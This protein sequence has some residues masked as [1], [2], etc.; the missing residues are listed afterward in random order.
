MRGVRTKATFDENNVAEITWKFYDAADCE[1][2]GSPT[3]TVR[4][5][6]TYA[7]G[8]SFTDE[9]AKERQPESDDATL[10]KLDYTWQSSWW[11]AHTNTG[12]ATLHKENFCTK[13]NIAQTGTV[14]SIN[15]GRDLVGDSCLDTDNNMAM[16]FA[17]TN[18]Y[19][20]VALAGGSLIWGGPMATCDEAKRPGHFDMD[21]G[22]WKPPSSWDISGRW[23]QGKCGADRTHQEITITQHTYRQRTWYYSDESCTQKFAT[24]W[25]EATYSLEGAGWD[26]STTNINIYPYKQVWSDLDDQA[27]DF[28]N[29]GAGGDCPGYIN[30]NE[31]KVL[32][33]EADDYDA[34]DVDDIQYDGRKC[35]PIWPMTGCSGDFHTI[36]LKD[37]MLSITRR[38][39]NGN[40]TVFSDVQLEAPIP[41]CSPSNRHQFS[42]SNMVQF[43]KLDF[44]HRDLVG[45]WSS[46]ECE[47][48][49]NGMGSMLK[50]VS[51]GKMKTL[52]KEIE[53]FSDDDCRMPLFSVQYS[54]M[55]WVDVPEGWRMPK[56]AAGGAAGDAGPPAW[57]GEEWE[58]PE[59]TERLDWEPVV[60]HNGKR[61]Q[62]GGAR[63]RD[64]PN[65]GNGFPDKWL[66]LRISVSSQTITN[67]N[68]Q[69]HEWLEDCGEMFAP[70]IATDISPAKKNKCM[71]KACSGVDDAV[72]IDGWGRLAMGGKTAWFDCGAQNNAVNYKAPLFR[73]RRGSRGD[74]GQD[75]LRQAQPLDS[76]T[77]ARAQLTKLGVVDSAL[78]QCDSRGLF[79]QKQCSGVECWCVDAS[80][81]MAQ[82]WS[83]VY[84][85]DEVV[86]C[87]P[88]ARF[89]S[90]DLAGR[91]APGAD[92]EQIGS[93]GY[94][95]RT[96]A[97]FHSRSL[98]ITRQF[99]A[100][101]GCTGTPALMA[102]SSGNYWLK[103]DPSG[104]ADWAD[105]KFHVRSRWWKADAT[106]WNTFNT[107]EQRTDI[108]YMGANVPQSINCG[109]AEWNSDSPHHDVLLTGCRL[110][111]V[112]NAVANCTMENHAVS[113]DRDTGKLSWWST[114][115]ADGA[116][117]CQ[118][119]RQGSNIQPV[120]F[121]RTV[122]ATDVQG[123][124]NSECSLGSK[125][126]VEVE[127]NKVSIQLDRYNEDSCVTKLSSWEWE[128][129]AVWGVENT[130]ND[131]AT[132]DVTLTSVSV[133]PHTL[134]TANNLAADAA[135]QASGAF[136]V[137]EDTMIKG[138]CMGV[139]GWGNCK[140][141]YLAI[142]VGTDG[143]LE[144]FLPTPS[145]DQQS[146]DQFSALC[147]RKNRADAPTSSLTVAR[148]W[149]KI[150]GKWEEGCISVSDKLQRSR[151]A[152]FTDM[153]EYR[154]ET[155]WHKGGTGCQAPVVKTVHV[156]TVETPW[157]LP[158]DVII[159]NFYMTEWKNTDILVTPLAGT[160]TYAASGTVP[161]AGSVEEYLTN[162]GKFWED[163]LNGGKI[164]QTM[165]VTG[166]PAGDACQ[167]I[168]GRCNYPY[169]NANSNIGVAMDQGV[170]SLFLSN[171]NDENHLEFTKATTDKDDGATGS[172][173]RWSCKTGGQCWEPMF[174]HAMCNCVPGTTGSNCAAGIAVG[175]GIPDPADVL[176]GSWINS[177]PIYAVSNVKIPVRLTGFRKLNPNSNKRVKLAAS[178]YNCAGYAPG[179][180]EWGGP[181]D[182]DGVGMVGPVDAPRGKYAVCFKHHHTWEMT[183]QVVMI[184][185]E[186]PNRVFFGAQSCA[187]A[188]ER[189]SD[190]CGCYFIRNPNKANVR[191]AAVSWGIRDL[192]PNPKSMADVTRLSGNV[193][194]YTLAT[195]AFNVDTTYPAVK[196]IHGDTDIHVA[197]GCCLRNPKLTPSM[198][199]EWIVDYPNLAVWGMCTE[200]SRKDG[201]DDD[202]ERLP[203][204]WPEAVAEGVK[205]K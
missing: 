88:P 39:G 112:I 175:Q 181:V 144:F 24:E 2:S 89:T 110:A 102:A 108:M 73:M 166:F 171:C 81:G 51:F 148:S 204:V 62:D 157:I 205:L 178:A 33:T 12:V 43:W 69:S 90:A 163:C 152:T 85:A 167:Q 133:T 122:R 162:G 91:W 29:N 189:H 99:W 135:C 75:G 14:W 118:V 5:V 65:R 13:M 16:K 32:T 7:I 169:G 92:C 125:L 127:G 146:A 115:N 34:D 164:G 61:A 172:C 120:N 10:Y 23:Y 72:R 156:G 79:K 95:G 134:A 37:G 113:L 182:K 203:R 105:L 18:Q 74:G 160:P 176:T 47:E 130:A 53:V 50:T 78:P 180:D 132:L 121:W 17:C 199:S 190:Y 52:S 170:M 93:T 101:S 104:N 38:Q 168:L 15:V 59:G 124:W 192:P 66:R 158:G 30:R 94:Y 155:T 201:D 143:S 183:N 21:G 194:E 129:N 6:G 71:W 46:L 195:R 114:N 161:A 165:R 3:I 100:Q 4:N 42:D 8:D 197:S 116:D 106:L 76:C 40:P 103:T 111:G 145:T 96:F 97:E 186:K 153:G 117:A 136:T 138:S 20:S 193:A 26:A 1:A 196:F 57:D 58:G 141:L 49:P 98:V 56:P 83:R 154:I 41:N 22:W 84:Y 159:D 149:P 45:D 140:A 139:Q 202:D 173:S 63:R 54:G 55:F 86:D 60:G 35:A 179:S 68:P 174:G 36:R 188:L 67:M 131:R 44:D 187:G 119:Q 107:K 109:N 191:D 123:N 147:W 77:R 70:G 184:E 82:P 11:T 137:G 31:P 177:E 28:F 87:D 126:M 142:R 9:T 185:G 151:L 150:A 27:Y 19:T 198:W 80:S 200:P 128:G 25:L 48:M 64:P